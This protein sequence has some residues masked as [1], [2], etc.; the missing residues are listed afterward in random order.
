MRVP[1][2]T[3]ASMLARAIKFL[4]MSEFGSSLPSLPRCQHMGVLAGGQPPGLHLPS[5]CLGHG[6]ARQGTEVQTGILWHLFHIWTPNTVLWLTPLQ[7]PAENLPRWVL[8]F[9]RENTG[10]KFPNFK[11]MRKT[12]VS[13]EISGGTTT[14][15]HKRGIGPLLKLFRE[16]P[17]HHIKHVLVPILWE[18]C[19][20]NNDPEYMHLKILMSNPFPPKF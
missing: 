18:R 17:S 3:A 19:Y 14:M 10:K 1:E 16:V 15:Y 12:I 7:R 4:N 5:A 2:R 8:P 9:T 11:T 13:E 6:P 20:I